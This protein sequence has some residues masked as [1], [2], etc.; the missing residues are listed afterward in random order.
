L[1]YSDATKW[2]ACP[3]DGPPRI[4]TTIACQKFILTVTWGAI[5][6][7]MADLMIRERTFNSEYFTEQIMRPLAGSN[8]GHSSPEIAHHQ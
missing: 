3:N 6:F 5:N 7:Y 8:I 4:R 1:E 2:C